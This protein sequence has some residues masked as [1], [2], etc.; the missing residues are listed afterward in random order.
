MNIE[1]PLDIH[2]NLN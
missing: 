1:Y 2:K